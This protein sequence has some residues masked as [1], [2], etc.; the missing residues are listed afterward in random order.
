MSEQKFAYASEATLPPRPENPLLPEEGKRNI[1]ITSALPYVNN[2]PHL[3]NIIGCVLS[4]DVFARYCRGRG[5]NAIYVCG[6]DEYGT[7]TETKALEENMTPQQICDKYH[8]I[9]REIYEWFGIAFDYF[10]RTS[11]HK[12][13]EIAQE[14]FWKCDRNGYTCEEVMDQ[15]FCEQ[16]S[17]FLADRY[18][19]GTCPN[20]AYA[21]ARGDQCDGCGKL[22]NAIEIRDPKCQ[23]C[24][25]TPIVRPSRHVLLDLPALRDN[26]ESWVNE[27]SVAG[28][29][30]SNSTQV[31]NSW[32][33][34]GLKPRCITRDLKWG[35][36]VPKEGFE[37]K[38]FYVWFDAPI[39]YLSITAWYT[40]Q[41]RQWW[42]N[43]E[44]VKLYQFM[45]KDNIPFHTVIFPC[46]L[47][48]TR[49]P[50]TM[51]H[52][53][54]TTEYLNYEDGKFSKSRSIGVFGDDARNTN[55]AAEVWRYYLLYNRP[56]ISDSAFL[57]DDFAAKNNS[58]LLNNLGNL[59]NRA[60]SFVTRKLQSVL[61]A[62]GELLPQDL[63]LIAKVNHEIKEYFE[64]M[65]AVHIKDGLKICMG[66]SRLGN[67]Y[68]Q[69]SAPWVLLD[70]DPV[71]CGTV[72]VVAANLIR[73]LA[74]L[75]QPY[76]PQFTQKVA[77]QLNL[78]LEEFHLQ[79]DEFEMKLPAR[80]TLGEVVPIFRKIEAN[81]LKELKER[82]RGR[83]E[84]KNDALQLPVDLVV[85]S[86]LSVDDVPN[87]EKLY[88]LQIDL[89]SH[90]RQIVSGLKLHYARE[91]LLGKKV[92]VIANLKPS[93]V[94]KV[95]SQGL[96]LT[97]VQKGA[98]ENGADIIGLLTTDAPIGTKVAPPGA[99]VVAAPNF[100]MK[101]SWDALP[102]GS[103]E[104]SQVVFSNVPLVAGEHNV[105]VE[106]VAA[107]AKIC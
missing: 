25:H 44:N 67:E 15:L 102:F 28:Q 17:R 56:E 10:G 81:E 95:N 30:T 88:T 76:V 47:L 24:R 60:L 85:G 46:T 71:R 101:K 78:P 83:Q 6:T 48:G 50:Y 68:M 20:C 14:I 32:I 33:R 35:T 4:A 80:H 55:I 3:G 19:T 75:L 104:A 107:G 90:Q 57:W 11:T 100:N 9:H 74:A 91:D 106:R 45:G 84:E 52:H 54:S 77:Q 53:I 61:P 70:S 37:D 65:E 86:I 26:L 40:D 31:T 16:C 59:V 34:D 2:V 73:V 49:D 99:K 7:A 103:N 36:P 97:G 96:V 66:I 93:S 82:F 12:Q 29:W 21:D 89:G 38:V 22:L 51:L 98:G 27:S 41:W 87:S 94:C 62:C 64:A 79:F 43:P 13:T 63:E 72:V 39:G 92:V 42:M 18:V 5:Y 1:L 8:K 23:R 58:E 105:T 69:S